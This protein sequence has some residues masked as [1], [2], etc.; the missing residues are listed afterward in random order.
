LRDII[1][2]RGGRDF[3]PPTKE[4]KVTVDFKG[5]VTDRKTVSVFFKALVKAGVSFH[6][7]D[8][9]ADIVEGGT[10]G[11]PTFDAAEAA[12]LDALM[13]DAFKVVGDEVYE[14]GLAVLA[15][16]GGSTVLGPCGGDIRCPDCVDKGA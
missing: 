11:H 7:D 8:S 15:G 14:V 9:F 5:P 16:C 10:N 4:D 12:R 2:V 3:Q 13:G 6:P 1:I